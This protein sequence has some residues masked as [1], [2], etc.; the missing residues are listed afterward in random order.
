M[1][2][3]RIEKIPA[4]V[5]KEIEERVNSLIRSLQEKRERMG[6]S[7]ERLAEELDISHMTIQFL[8]QR[9]RDPSLPMLFYICRYLGIELSWKDISSRQEIIENDDPR[10]RKGAYRNLLPLYSFTAAA[11][12]FHQAEEAEPLGWVEIKGHG[13]LQRSMFVARAVGASMEPKIHDGDLLVFRANPEGTRNGKIVLAQYRDAAD[14]GSA[15]S[16]V[17]KVYS[18]T[19]AAGADGELAHKRILLRSLNPDYSHIEIP[20]GRAENFRIIAEFLFVI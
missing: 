12:R 18:S 20:P 3:R 15:G 5:R 13:K 1:R 11:G 4:K 19:K 6:L 9:R 14:S 17:V 16:F 7:Q 8:E 10:V 2:Q